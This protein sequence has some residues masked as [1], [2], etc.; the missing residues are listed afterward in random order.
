[1]ASVNDAKK[2]RFWWQHEVDHDLE[3]ADAI[4]ELACTAWHPVNDPPTDKDANIF[5]MVLYAY[6]KSGEWH[7][8]QGR[9]H[10]A[11]NT[12]APDLW[13]RVRDVVLMPEGDD[14]TS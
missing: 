12:V 7:V 10:G 9:W 13:A 4:Q 1:M 11:D 5:G 3:C 6:C 14:G 2:V 8:W